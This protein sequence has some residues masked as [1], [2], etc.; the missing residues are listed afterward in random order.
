MHSLWPYWPYR[1]PVR[2]EA[3]THDE[4]SDGAGKDSVWLKDFVLLLYLVFF[5]REAKRLM[6]QEGA[7][8]R[9]ACTRRE[10]AS[11]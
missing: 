8:G 11:L 3:I 4:R 5:V 6:G 9:T 10:S 7:V 1:P 2:F